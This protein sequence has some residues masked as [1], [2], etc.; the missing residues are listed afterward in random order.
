[1]NKQLSAV[2]LSLRRRGR[3][4]FEGRLNF[5]FGNM[6]IS[7]GHLDMEKESLNPIFKGNPKKGEVGTSA[8]YH[9]K[10]LPP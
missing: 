1:M 3:S 7:M 6:N 8:Q 2:F 5:Q 10:L 4:H 9:R